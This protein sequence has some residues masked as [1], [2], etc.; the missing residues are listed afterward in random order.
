MAICCN[1]LG[2][3]TEHPHTSH[4]LVFLCTHD[5]VA[6]DIGSRCGARHTIHV[7]C[8]WV[9]VR[10]DLSS[11]LHF[12]LS[13]VS[14]IFC[15]ILLIFIFTF[16]VGRF[17]EKYPVRFR[18]WGVW[19]F[20]QQHPSHRSGLRHL[21]ETDD[22]C[23]EPCAQSP[24]S[25]V[26]KQHVLTHIRDEKRQA[27]PGSRGERNRCRHVATWPAFAYTVGTTVGGQK[28]RPC[29]HWA[30]ATGKSDR[31]RHV[32]RRRQQ[33][34]RQGRLPS[35]RCTS[36]WWH[37]SCEPHLISPERGWVMPVWHLP[38][39]RSIGDC[40]ENPLAEPTQFFIPCDIRNGFGAARR[41]DAVEGARRWCPVLGAVNRTP[42]HFTFSRVS[43]HS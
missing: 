39:R 8:A 2:M 14:P 13:T 5:S 9:V 40:V 19:L 21:T 25:D 41:G 26:R 15:F 1:R 32:P 24:K 43:L 35:R 18:E 37:P 6:H 3:R 17:G 23:I 28:A 30:L 22:C 12:A 20:G 11:T 4:F 27:H 42:S 10:F 29:V 33:E 36:S 38:C 7:S 16:Y 31:R 34:A